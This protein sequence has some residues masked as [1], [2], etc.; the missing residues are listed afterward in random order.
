MA[1]RVRLLATLVASGLLVVVLGCTP[2]GPGAVTPEPATVPADAT[3]APSTSPERPFPDTPRTTTEASTSEPEPEPSGSVDAPPPFRA[4][5]TT[6]LAGDLTASWRPGC[7]VGPEGLRTVEV[8]HWGYDGRVR[9]GRLVVA[10][11]LT[12]SVAAVMGELYAAGFPIEEMSPVEAYGGDDEASMAANNTSAFNC[13]AV[14]GGSSWSEHAYGRAI[15]VNPLVN[16]YVADTYVLPPGGAAYLDRDGL[17]TG[18]I[19]DGDATVTAFAVHGWE[20]G[21]SW[22]S[23]KNYQHFSTTGR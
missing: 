3:S 20:W 13:R 1:G 4:T 2:I 8:T 23:P 22:V 6:V 18:M 10:A 15:D 16:P 5:V 7:P 14:T 9:T 21:G 12:A 17:G 19:R 11:E